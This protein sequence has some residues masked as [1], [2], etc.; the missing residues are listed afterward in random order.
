MFVLS[1]KQYKCAVVN[2]HARR[3]DEL[4]NSAVG[5]NANSLFLTYLFTHGFS[6]ISITP[7]DECIL[8]RRDVKCV[9]LK[10]AHFATKIRKYF[11]TQHPDSDSTIR[12]QPQWAC[13]LIYGSFFADFTLK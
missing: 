11:D 10:D 6:K 13:A 2:Q 8:L 3:C 1:D 5:I 7:L 9:H 12:M 4:V